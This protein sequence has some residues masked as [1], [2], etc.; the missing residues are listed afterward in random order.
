MSEYY[1]EVTVMIS[2]NV[3][4]CVALALLF[5]AVLLGVLRYTPRRSAEYVFSHTTLR[6]VRRRKHLVSLRL[7]SVIS[8]VLFALAIYSESR[9]AIRQV[10]M[11][12]LSMSYPSPLQFWLTAITIMI[13][14]GIMFAVSTFVMGYLSEMI[15]YG[16]LIR[17]IRFIKRNG[18]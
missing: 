9:F 4:P 17:K 2:N 1:N 13:I 7:Y 14:M 3:W 16:Y 18:K 15:R 12:D 8:G 11:T 10:C 5:G 6:C